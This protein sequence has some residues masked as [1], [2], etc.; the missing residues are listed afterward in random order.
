MK[1]N[2]TSFIPGPIK[3]WP[4]KFGG[5]KKFRKKKKAIGDKSPMA[6]FCFLLAGVGMGETKLVNIGVAHL[7]PGFV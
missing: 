4:G 7:I 2:Y 3:E 6:A 1:T 5:L